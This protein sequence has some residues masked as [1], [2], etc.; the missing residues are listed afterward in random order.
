M[1]KN[2]KLSNSEV[3]KRVVT[4]ILRA[5]TKFKVPPYIV[6]ANQFWMCANNEV[7]DWQMR[8]IGSFRRVRSEEFPVPPGAEKIGNS[9][10]YKKFIGREAKLANFRCHTTTIKELFHIAKLR[11]NDIFK[12][13]VMPDAHIEEHDSYALNAFCKFAQYYKPHGIVNLGDFM[14]MDAVTHWPAPDARPRRLVPQIAV[15]RGLLASIDEACGKQCTFKR[16]LIGNHEDWL[17]QYLVGKIPEVLYDLEQLGVNL[18]FQE[19][20]GLPEFGYKTIPLNEI[21]RIGE[22]CHFIHGYYTQKHHAAKHLEVFGVNVY[23]GHLHDVQQH[24]TVSVNG[25]HE[26][27]SLGCLRDLNA[28][29]LKGKPNNWS[30]AFGIFEFT[31]D[32]YYTRYIPTIIDGK[33]SFNGKF[34]DGTTL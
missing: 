10:G 23:Y 1:S 14:E 31:A 27:M 7:T 16:F 30:H 15:A 11:T 2:E 32:G 22:H 4:I 12:L 33:F 26:A 29:F 24:S 25:V 20:L 21:L 5:A 3:K 18:N 28:E 6:H 19:L 17:D 34:F 13:L 9:K 8:K